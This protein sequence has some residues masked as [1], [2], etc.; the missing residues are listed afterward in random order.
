M[1]ERPVRYLIRNVKEAVGNGSLEFRV[2]ATQVMYLGEFLSRGEYL[3]L[4]NLLMLPRER[5]PDRDL[6]QAKGRMMTSLFTGKQSN[7]ETEQG[8]GENCQSMLRLL[9]DRNHGTEREKHTSPKQR[10]IGRKCQK[11][12]E[13]GLPSLSKAHKGSRSG[14]HGWGICRYRQCFVLIS[15]F[16]ESCPLEAVSWQWFHPA[17]PTVPFSSGFFVANSSSSFG[18]S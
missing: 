18:L 11:W 16:G 15:V 14:R 1:F 12:A 7:W 3:K 10:G 13:W 5:V 4:C 8:A 9:L 6:I 2:K 17:V